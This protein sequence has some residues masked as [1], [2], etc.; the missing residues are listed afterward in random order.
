[1]ATRALYFLQTVMDAE[2]P[3]LH[4]NYVRISM[5]KLVRQFGLARGIAETQG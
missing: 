4:L 2:S 1:M 5:W 3:P